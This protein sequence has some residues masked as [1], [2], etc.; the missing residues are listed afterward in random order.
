MT[1]FKLILIN[2]KLKTVRHFVIFYNFPDKVLDSYLKNN[3]FS[4]KFKVD[5]IRIWTDWALLDFTIDQKCG[6]AKML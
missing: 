1:F 5:F 3:L 2:V 6:Q 4:V